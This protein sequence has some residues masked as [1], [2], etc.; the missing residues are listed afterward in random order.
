MN[1]AEKGALAF[2][3]GLI[4]V[5]HLM[6]WPVAGVLIT[7][8]LIVYALIKVTRRCDYAR[9]SKIKVRPSIGSGPNEA[10]PVNCRSS[11]LASSRN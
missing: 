7:I 8:G 11:L 1:G 5:Y 4:I 10:R 6:R 9:P 3:A 2:F